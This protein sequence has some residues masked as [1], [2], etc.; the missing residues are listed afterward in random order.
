MSDHVLKIIPTDRRYVPAREVHERA[1][2]LLQELAPGEG[3]IKASDKLMYIDAGE[4]LERIVCPLCRSALDRYK[5][6]ISEWYSRIDEELTEKDVES[7]NVITPCCNASVPFQELGFEDGGI[8]RF[9]LVIW[10]PDLRSLT[11]R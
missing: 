8:A 4:A 5:E 1:L 11:A 10:N 9:E 3:E 7:L 6:S 2:K